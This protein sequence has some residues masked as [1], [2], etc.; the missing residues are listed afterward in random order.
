MIGSNCLIEPGAVVRESILDDYTR[1][2]SAANVSNS[3][4]FVGKL[5]DRYGASVDIN[6]ADIGW[7][8]DDARRQVLHDPV[9]EALREAAGG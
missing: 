4:V 5:I 3:I 7:L 9:Y 8:L 6:E 1:V 2:S